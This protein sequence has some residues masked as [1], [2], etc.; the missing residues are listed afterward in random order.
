MTPVVALDLCYPDMVDE[1]GERLEGK[2]SCTPVLVGKC[3]NTK[4]IFAHLLPSKEVNNKLVQAVIKDIA[5]LGHV[6][7]VIKTDQE[8][9]TKN[10]A[11]RIQEARVQ[12]TLVEHSAQYEP[13]SNGGAER[14]VRTVKELICTYKDAIESRLKAPLPENHPIWA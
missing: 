1:H 11:N 3:S 9:A 8:P 14:G 13:Q 7:V 2:S 12:S 6:A 10:L 5:N 4:A